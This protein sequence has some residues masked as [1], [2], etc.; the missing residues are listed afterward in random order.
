MTEGLLQ[1]KLFLAESA[2]LYNLRG[3]P[4]VSTILD[5]RS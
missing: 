5:V 1:S 4:L 2:P 3:F